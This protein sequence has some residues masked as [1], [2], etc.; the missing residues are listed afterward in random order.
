MNQFCVRFYVTATSVRRDQ[1]PPR[2]TMTYKEDF[3]TERK[4]RKKAYVDKRDCVA[5]GACV[6]VCPKAAISIHKGSFAIVDEEICVGCKRCT[7]VC[8]AST[9]FMKGD[10]G[11]E[12]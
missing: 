3:M 9:I 11:D 12:E 2:K 5:C 7:I 4:Q 1:L 6:A 8:P 10:S